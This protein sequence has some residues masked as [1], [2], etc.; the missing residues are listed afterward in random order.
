MTPRNPEPDYTPPPLIDLPVFGEVPD[1]ASERTPATTHQNLSPMGLLAAASRNPSAD[2]TP[3]ANHQTPPQT[4]I[5]DPLPTRDHLVDDTT[6][7]DTDS[8]LEALHIDLGP[9]LDPTEI[10]LL[11]EE[12]TERDQSQRQSRQRDAEEAAAEGRSAPEFTADDELALG[13]SICRDVVARHMDTIARSGGTVHDRTTQDALV[14]AVFDRLYRLGPLQPIVE[15]PDV[16]NILI[17][18]DSCHVMRPD[19]TTLSVPSPF[20]SDR[21]LVD[22]LQSMANRD[23]AGGREFAPVSP[24]LRLNLP[25]G[26]RLSAMNWTTQRPSV[27][28]RLHRHKDID[29]PRLVDMKVMD[30][31]LAPILQGAS[32]SGASMVISGPMGAGKTTLLRALVAALPPETR[33][34]TAET[35][36]ELF[37]D[38]LPGRA[39]FVVSA[40][41][42]E[43]GGERNPVTGAK[44]GSFTLDDQL[45]EFVR[46]QLELVIVGEVA[47]KE[48]VALFKAMQMAKG[49]M[50]TTHAYHARG[51]INRLVTCAMEAGVTTQYAERQVAEHVNVIVQLDTKWI[52]DPELGRTSRRFISEVAWVEPDYDTARPQLTTLYRGNPDGT[53]Q[54]GTFPDPLRDRLIAVG[55]GPHEIPAN[56]LFTRTEQE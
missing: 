28:I 30:A 47:G 14:R 32:R 33:I 17:N 52:N 16:E 36:R 6:G 54:F 15:A 53:G 4:P 35:E 21:E 7:T 44:E 34:G 41:I 5:L 26:I 48:I 50:T 2:H 49:S 51:A 9:R 23:P 39:P 12:A 56:E 24:G 25:G 38:E 10:E 18:G 43:G 29:L 45:Y 20:T 11:V 27:A 8:A 19:G 40:E 46:Q 55:L 31:R 13:A 1:P 37:L 22:W 42:L 3:S